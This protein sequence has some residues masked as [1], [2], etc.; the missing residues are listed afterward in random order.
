M[1][2][3]ARLDIDNRTDVRGLSNVGVGFVGDPRPARPRGYRVS[4][5]CRERVWLICPHPNPLPRGEG[6]V[7][8]PHAPPWVPDQAR[9]GEGRPT[10]VSDPSAT[11]GMTVLWWVP[12]VP[13]M[14]G[15]REW[16]AFRLGV[17]GGREGDPARPRPPW[18]PDQAR[19]GEGGQTTVSD[20][21]ATLGMTVLWWVPGVSL[22]PTTPKRQA[23][24]PRIRRA[25]DNRYQ[26]GRRRA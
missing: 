16:V 25:G 2:H 6:E 21:S 9:S 3:V 26:W 5:V 19:S 15:E 18:V 10:T 4:P 1:L 22:T 8:G 13:S 11:L 20:P 14:S 23:T 24:H 12:G 7:V 17:V